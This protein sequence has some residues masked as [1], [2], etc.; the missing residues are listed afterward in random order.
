MQ[1]DLLSKPSGR[2]AIVTASGFTFDLATGDA[3]GVTVADVAR[4]LA[5]QPRWCGAT[6]EFYS[7]AEHSV[8][9]SLLVPV[10]QAYNALF[11]D[12]L[13]SITGDWPSP[14]KVYLGR[15][16]INQKLEPLE[17]AFRRRFGFRSHVPEV[18]TADLIA[19]ATELRDL[20]PGSWMDWGHLPPPAPEKIVPVGPERAM[21]LFLARYEQVKHLAIKEAPPKRAPRHTRRVA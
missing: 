20:L 13:E 4:S 3:S 19:M 2:T 18:K 21:E 1:L 14:I 15:D 12:I 16:F 7:V 9:V 5:F 11:H 10:D 8:F 6:K 17:A